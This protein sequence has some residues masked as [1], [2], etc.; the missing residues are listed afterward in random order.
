VGGLVQ[1][2]TERK[3]THAGATQWQEFLNFVQKSHG[4]IQIGSITSIFPFLCFESSVMILMESCF[5]F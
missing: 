1:K 3:K 5:D 2:G 4:F